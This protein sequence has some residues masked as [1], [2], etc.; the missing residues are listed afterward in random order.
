[1]YFQRIGASGFV[2]GSIRTVEAPHAP[3]LRLRFSMLVDGT[4]EAID[5]RIR[6]ILPGDNGAIASALITGKRDTISTP[7]N[8]AMYVSGLAHVLSISGYHMAVV[9]GIMFFTLRALFA[10]MPAF[11][12]RHPIKKWAAL[13]ALGAAAFYL[14]LS[15]AE[16]ATQRS[17]IMIAI[18][19]IGVMVDRPTLTFRTLTVA[20]FGVLLLAPEAVIHPS[21][22]MSFAATLALVAGYQQGL[23]WMSKGGDTPLAA[24][25]ALWGGREIVGLLIVSLLA[26]TATIP[27]IAYHFHRISPY[28]VIANLIAM[29]VVSAWIMPVGILG[30]MIMPLGLD[31]FCWRLMG[32]GIEWMT[33]VALWVTSFPGALGRIAAFGAGPLL[34]CTAGL[35]VL[36]LFKT[37]LRFIGAFLIAGA[38]ILMVRAPQ[39][40]VL[41]AADG[42]AIAL[43]GENGRLSM[44][45]SGS[46]VFA[47]REW[48]AAD[49]DAR[50]PKDATLGE[51]IRCDAAGC[52]GKL[53][54]GSLIAI[55]K[56]VEAFEE[57][58]RRAVLVV[59]VRDAPPGCAAVV[60]DR[61]VW[62][63]SGAMALR[64]RG[65]EFEITATRSPGYD[66]PWARA[67]AGQEQATVPGGTMPAR[68]RD[69]TP[70]TDD[71]DAGD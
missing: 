24:K 47:F 29:P 62:R 52:V 5:K 10:L 59:S 34:V 25:I 14:V 55:A 37:P 22:Q 51:G 27:Y 48:L 70:R 39:P 63:R 71:L 33:F 15:G 40:D 56:T 44:V 12:N 35:V 49:A 21:F 67:V 28:G 45:K 42:S 23:P 6:T 64:R 19:L 69:A 60:I 46:D 50:T 20:A 66:R 38:A 1:M 30:L 16:V 53:R 54:D 61:N 36:C 13:A 7:V 4:R 41:I 57:D 9:A 58:C 8:E 18:V 3:G 2:L 17:F 32:G 65:E 26:G 31:G 68:P 11:G 43:R